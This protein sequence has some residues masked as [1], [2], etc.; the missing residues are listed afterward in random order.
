MSIWVRISNLQN[1][2]ISNTGQVLSIRRGRLLAQRLDKYGY[3]RVDCW[4]NNKRITC[5]VARLVALY[6]V[7]NPENKPEVNHKNGEQKQ[8]N[9]VSNLEWVT[10]PEN[11]QHAFATGLMSSNW[12][13]S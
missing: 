13:T 12:H 5:S 2:A 9:A 8:N 11:I 7:P 1:Y 4:Q 10:R 6:H 3:Q